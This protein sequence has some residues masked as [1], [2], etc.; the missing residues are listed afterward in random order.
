[1]TK[2]SDEVW[3]RIRAKLNDHE[4]EM[5]R[6]FTESPYA[7]RELRNK[8]EFVEAMIKISDVFGKEKS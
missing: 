2:L 7:Q 5:V 1:M 6:R 3:A 4:Y 8:R